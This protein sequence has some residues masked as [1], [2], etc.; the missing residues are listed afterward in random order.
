[1]NARSGSVL[2]MRSRSRWFEPYHKNF[3]VSLNE[4]RYYL[5]ST[6]STLETFRHD[7]KIVDW[8]VIHQFKQRRKKLPIYNVCIVLD[9]SL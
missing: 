7:I 4:T 2:D 6:G 5:L 9:F 8:D 1:M 3:V